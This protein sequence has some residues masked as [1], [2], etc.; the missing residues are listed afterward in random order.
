[1]RV[2][3]HLG[4]VGLLIDGHKDFVEKRLEII[5]LHPVHHEPFQRGHY[6]WSRTVENVRSRARKRTREHRTNKREREGER[7]RKKA[8]PKGR[9]KRGQNPM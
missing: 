6:T 8:R 9:G 2:E 1:M 4:H 5:P 3:A 7:D